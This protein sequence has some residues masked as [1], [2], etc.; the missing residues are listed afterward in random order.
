MIEYLLRR[1]TKND[2][3]FLA[4]T[5]I[6]AEKGTSGKCNYSTLFNISE[7]EARDCIIAMFEQEIEGCE[8]YAGNY[9]VTEYDGE[10]VAALG[11]WIECFGGCMPSG[12]LKSNLINY[13][14]KKE[15]I[16]F[17]LT[18]MSILDD[19]VAERE[20]MT[21]QLEYL[22]VSENHRGKGLVKDLARMHEETGKLAYPA[23]RKVQSQVFKNNIPVLTLFGKFGYKVVKS[24]KSNNPEILNYIASDEKYIIEKEFY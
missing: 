20:P 9:F 22:Y 8:F 7:N 6:A 19:L 10:P 11:S 18:K 4:S 5:V 13:T 17:L 15:S 21:L 23:L 1:A 16:E 12:I 3:P 24:Y 2:I 14:F